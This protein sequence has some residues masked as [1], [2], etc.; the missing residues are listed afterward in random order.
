MKTAKRL[1]LA[2]ETC[3]LL[4]ICLVDLVST[5]WL[6]STDRALEGNPIMAFYLQHS[7]CA[8]VLAKVMIAGFAFFVVEWGRRRR[9]QFVRGLLRLAILAYI[10]VYALGCLNQDLLASQNNSHVY[11][12]AFM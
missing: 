10:S 12:A 6:V 11:P 9:P 2:M 4:A 3:I 1:N 5:I 7:L 8:L